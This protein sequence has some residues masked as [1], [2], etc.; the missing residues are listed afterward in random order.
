MASA[1]H[2]RN[3]VLTMHDGFWI[4]AAV[5]ARRKKGGIKIREDGAPGDLYIR[6]K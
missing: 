2:G 1:R 4:S 5:S 3:P 6:C